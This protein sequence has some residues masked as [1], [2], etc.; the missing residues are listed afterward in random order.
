M[1]RSIERFTTWYRHAART[2]ITPP[3]AIIAS[4][5]GRDV[6]HRENVNRRASWIPSSRSHSEKR[7]TR[8]PRLITAMLVRTH[9]RN[10]RSFERYST[11]RFS[12][13]GPGTFFDAGSVTAA[14]N[15]RA[16][17]FLPNSGVRV[18]L[19]RVRVP[20]RTRVAGGPR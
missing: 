14:K 3:N 16:K 4:P 7:A 11:A 12:G 10:V 8:N 2:A 1:P 9:A 18:L 15:A 6:F 19:F 13:G 5:I 17:P 20:R